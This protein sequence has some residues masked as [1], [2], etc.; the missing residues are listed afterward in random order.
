M[1]QVMGLLACGLCA[2]VLSGA[3]G[4]GGG[5][6][7]IPLLVFV[8]RYPQVT[9]NGVSLVA[10]LAPV[11]LLGVLAYYRAG[12]IGA[13]DVKAGLLIGVGISLGV[14][15]GARLALSLPV[16]ILQRAFG[17]FLMAVALRF[18]FG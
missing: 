9:A 13:N 2:G 7:L 4:I 14:Y 12:K 17:L 8:M 16:G 15:L 18:L 3:F 11:G 10:L 1:Y 6:I 5:V